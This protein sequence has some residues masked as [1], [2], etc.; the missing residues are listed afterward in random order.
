M[1][2]ST[3]C[4]R[5]ATAALAQHQRPQVRW[6][7]RKRDG[8]RTDRSEQRHGG[9]YVAEARQKGVATGWVAAGG[10]VGR[11]QEEPNVAGF[12]V[13]AAR[14]SATRARQRITINHR[15]RGDMGSKREK[16]FNTRK[17][18]GERLY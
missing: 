3:R 11:Q 13:K 18:R 9:Y 14:I 12:L 5:D 7:A 17:G 10:D 6:N 8:R 1:R 4:S 16:R 15:K 2:Q